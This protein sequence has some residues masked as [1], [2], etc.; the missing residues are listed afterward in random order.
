VLRALVGCTP[1]GLVVGDRVKG[2][3]VAAVLAEFESS[4]P[5]L[6]YGELVKFFDNDGHRFEQFYSLFKVLAFDQIVIQHFESLFQGLQ[7]HLTPHYKMK[8]PLIFREDHSNN[9]YP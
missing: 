1:T 6:L 8:Y 3:L 2:G 7:I 9:K 4:D 5:C